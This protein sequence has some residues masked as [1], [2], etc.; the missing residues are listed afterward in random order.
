MI[1]LRTFGAYAPCGAKRLARRAASGCRRHVKTDPVSER[2]KWISFRM[3]LTPGRVRADADGAEMVWRDPG[4]CRFNAAGPMRF[5]DD[6]E[7]CADRRTQVA[8]RRWSGE[9]F[10][11]P[12]GSP[13]DG[14]KQIPSRAV[15]TARTHG[16]SLAKSDDASQTVRPLDKRAI[17]GAKSHGESGRTPRE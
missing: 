1:L 13:P 17:R 14:H 15:S 16:C 3:P 7:T 9:L 10:A 12:R 4:R 6:G 11:S 5:A 2:R 8:G